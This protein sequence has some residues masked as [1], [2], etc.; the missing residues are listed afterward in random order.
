MKLMANKIL[1]VGGQGYIGSHL[2]SEMESAGIAFDVCDYGARGGASVE[3]KF[4]FD[5][6]NLSAD[7]LAEYGVVLW[8]AGHSSVAS[9]VA[10]P[11]GAVSNNC[12][13]L[14]RLAEKLQ[15][16]ARMIYAST[17]SLYSRKDVIISDADESAEMVAPSQNA[18]DMSKYVFD[19]L[20]LNFLN[21]V[22]ALRM[23][24][25]SG[26][27][28]N[29]RPELVFNAMNLSA[30]N[31]GKVFLKN[32][33]SRRTIL[34]LSDLWRFVRQV[35]ASEAEPGIYN[36]GSHSSTLA[37]LAQGIAN[38]WGAEVVD[39][40]S[41]QTY[42]FQLGLSKMNSVIGR[43]RDDFDLK[44]ECFQFIEKCKISSNLFVK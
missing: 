21:N 5:Y 6:K 10:D 23:G 17:A 38:A 13:E 24:T 18:Y 29:L 19:Y 12:I 15:P 7:Q 3:T 35:L 43:F 2:A 31:Q 25:V 9:S 28:P 39:Q 32:G 36:L 4:P 30:V 44:S 16:T 41:T 37:D 22:Y 42:S 40:G 1:L 14:F 27:S 20:A 34:M 11:I 33:Q 26:Y 8:F